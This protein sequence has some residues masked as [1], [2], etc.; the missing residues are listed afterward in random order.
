MD[1]S[2]NNHA[3]PGIHIREM[4]DLVILLGKVSDLILVLTAVVVV[5]RTGALLLNEVIIVVLVERRL[6]D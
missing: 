6:I 1:R 2:G 4:L 3:A 5:L